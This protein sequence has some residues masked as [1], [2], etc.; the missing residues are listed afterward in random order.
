MDRKAVKHDLEFYPQLRERKNKN[1]YEAMKLERKHKTGLP[2]SKIQA[3]IEDAA[4]LDRNWR[5]VL[6]NNPRLRGK[7]YEEKTKL[8]IEKQLELGYW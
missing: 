8:E 3:L 2:I 6:Q 4:T 5:H 1:K 7:D